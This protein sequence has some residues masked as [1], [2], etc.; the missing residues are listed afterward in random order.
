MPIEERQ[1]RK[2]EGRVLVMDDDPGIRR[3]AARMLMSLGYEVVTVEDGVAALEAW[4]T[5]VR[6]GVRFD[7]AILDL[8]VPGGMGGCETVE[9]IRALDQGAV[10]VVSSGYSDDSSLVEYHDAGFDSAIP[11]PYTPDMLGRSLAEAFESRRRG[12]QAS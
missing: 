2:G 12:S 9:R 11:K 1:I 4:D 3:S 6:S 5:A 7:L 8:T 10:V